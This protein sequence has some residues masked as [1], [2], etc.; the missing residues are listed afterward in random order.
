[1]LEEVAFI[2]FLSFY[3]LYGFVVILW[4][5][6]ESQEL[7]Q[8]FSFYR[9]TTYSV[10]AKE[11]DLIRYSQTVNLAFIANTSILISIL[12]YILMHVLLKLYHL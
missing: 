2:S 8:R 5:T 9:T 3:I 12:I 11:N 4:L 1:M 7:G 10:L 6:D